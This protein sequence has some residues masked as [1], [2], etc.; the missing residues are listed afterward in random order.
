MLYTKH[1]L[2]L[3]MLICFVATGMV[4]QDGGWKAPESADTIKNPYTTNEAFVEAGKAVYNT[5]C[6]NCHGRSGEG[7]GPAGLGLDPA[8]A[9]F[10]SEKVQAQTD[11]ALFWKLTTGKPPMAPYKDVLSEE[12]RWQVVAYIRNFKK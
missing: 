9:D 2:S 10:T 7:D 12:K 11:G 4:W 1:I 6:W 5:Y 8:P 3:F